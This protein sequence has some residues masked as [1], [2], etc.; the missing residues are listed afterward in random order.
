MREP[1]WELDGRELDNG[2]EYHAN[3][4]ETFWIPSRVERDNLQQ[5]DF[6]KL[7]F[8][9]CVDD[10][11]DPVAVE[12]MWIL[13]RG[14]LGDTYFGILDNEPDA[15]AENEEFWAGTELPFR[16]EHVINITPADQESIDFARLPP[17]RPWPRD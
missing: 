4:P 16:A 14:K 8:R 12:R 1:D 13:V 2:E 9:I 5:G 11:E 3:A 17:R 10:E 7:I 6:A 15:L